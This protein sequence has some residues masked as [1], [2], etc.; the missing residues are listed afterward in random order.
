MK[1]IK[2]LLAKGADARAKTKRGDVMWYAEDCGLEELI[3]LVRKH[4]R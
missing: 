2:L 4:R 1:I 3:E